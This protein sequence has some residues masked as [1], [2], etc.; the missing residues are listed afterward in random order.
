MLLRKKRRKNNMFNFFKEFNITYYY[1]NIFA[2]LDNLVNR[3][4]FYRYAVFFYYVVYLY[5]LLGL[6]IVLHFAAISPSLFMKHLKVFPVL[7]GIFWY[8]LL[9]ELVSEKVGYDRLSFINFD[10]LFLL[11]WSDVSDTSFYVVFY[12]YM[13][14]ISWVT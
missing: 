11:L 6:S 9:A 12:Y 1:S 10:D 13:L 2:Y 3:V 8:D 5:Y 7:N 4:A 14:F